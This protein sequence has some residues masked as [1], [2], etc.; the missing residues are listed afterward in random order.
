MPAYSHPTHETISNME[1]TSRLFNFEGN[2]SEYIKY[3]ELRL[4]EVQSLIPSSP[5]SSSKPRSSSLEPSKARESRFINLSVEKF[6]S[7]PRKGTLRSRTKPAQWE[8]ELSKFLSSLPEPDKWHHARKIAGFP[9]NERNKLAIQLLLGRPST[10]AQVLHPSRI[11]ECPSLL[12]TDN[13]DLILRGCSYGNFTIQCEEDGK[14]AVRVAKYQQL[15]FISYCAVLLSLGNSRQTID[16][17]MRRYISDSD[18]KN[19]ERY[20][21]GSLWVNRCISQLLKQGWGYKS[22]ELFLLCTYQN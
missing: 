2:D 3:L 5:S 13:E 7:N 21:S 11:S 15:V 20:R 1:A 14:F 17:M 16:W 9:T 4:L 8:R 6:N 18:N 10:S 12:P 22:W 19:L